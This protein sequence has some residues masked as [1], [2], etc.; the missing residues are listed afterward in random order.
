MQRAKGKI[1]IFTH[2]HKLGSAALLARFRLARCGSNNV[3]L[4]LLLC[5]YRRRQRQFSALYNYSSFTAVHYLIKIEY[6]YLKAVQNTLQRSLIHELT[7]TARFGHYLFA[8]L[9]QL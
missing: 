1:E 7:K 4:A 9:S 2:I 6:I 3:N 8:S 5:A